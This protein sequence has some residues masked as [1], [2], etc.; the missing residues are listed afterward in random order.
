MR[1]LRS[2]LVTLAILLGLG[3]AF[4]QQG[5]NLASPQQKAQQEKA[6]HDQR[7]S[8]RHHRAEL[9]HADRPAGRVL[10]VREW[11][12]DHARRAGRQPDR[13]GQVLGAQQ[14]ARRTA[15]HGVSTAADRR[16]APAHPRRRQQG[17]GRERQRPVSPSCLPSSVNVRELPRQI[18][19]GNSGDA[20]PRLRAHRRQDPAGQPGEPHRRRRNPR[21]RRVEVT[22]RVFAPRVAPRRN[23][24][25]ARSRPLS[26]A[27]WRDC[28]A[29]RGRDRRSRAPRRDRA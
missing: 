17:A 28:S 1:A 22:L 5:E 8:G 26:L 3:L 21:A 11:P 15:D 29:V 20:Q 18:N 14:R 10:G 25:R 9:A 23:S 19:A 7:R 16:A 24:V 12:A 2:G 13:P 6:Q 27:N 4:A